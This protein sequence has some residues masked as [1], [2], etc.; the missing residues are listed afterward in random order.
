MQLVPVVWQN[1]F[2]NE[3]DVYVNGE[4]EQRRGRKLRHEIL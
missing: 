2:L 3:H 4:E 1:G